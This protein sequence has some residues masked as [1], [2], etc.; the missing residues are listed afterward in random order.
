M[1]KKDNIKLYYTKKHI[2]NKLNKTFLEIKFNKEK[3][4]E[5]ILWEN[6]I[7][8]IMKCCKSNLS[9][10]TLLGCNSKTLTSI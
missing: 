10:T 1:T 6:S 8:R 5:N 2:E 9:Y 7:N 4:L 3:S